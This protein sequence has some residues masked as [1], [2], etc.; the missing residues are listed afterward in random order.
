MDEHGTAE[1]G[2]LALKAGDERVRVLALRFIAESGYGKPR[3]S[4]E[5]SG[6]VTHRYLATFD[7][8]DSDLSLAEAEQS[9]SEI[10]H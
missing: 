4:V 7:S 2:T 5:I 1:L 8:T 3:E 9:R 10:R 6:E